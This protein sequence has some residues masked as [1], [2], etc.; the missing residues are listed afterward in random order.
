MFC[1]E[2]PHL[3]YNMATQIGRLISTLLGIWQSLK[4]VVTSKNLRICTLHDDDHTFINFVKIYRW[5]DISQADKGVTVI[6][7]SKYGWHV[8]D[9]I[10]QLS[11]LKAPKNPDANCD[12]HE[13][14]IYYAVMPHKGSFQSAKV[15]QKAYELNI[16]GSNNVPLLPTSKQQAQYGFMFLN[17]NWIFK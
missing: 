3:R 10:V 7:D 9:N 12:M 14:F 4:F 13:H 15:I 17:K 1:P 8:R 5:M 11:L 2:T 6:T 16:L